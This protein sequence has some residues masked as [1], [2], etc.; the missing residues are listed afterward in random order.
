MI[1]WGTGRE[2]KGFVAIRPPKIRDLR[3]TLGP[4]ACVRQGRED[5][6]RFQPPMYSPSAPRSLCQQT[7]QHGIGSPHTSRFQNRR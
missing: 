5:R 6:V 4:K 3:C 1:Q 2:E 7:L